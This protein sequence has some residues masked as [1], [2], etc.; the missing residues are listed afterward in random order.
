MGR[1]GADCIYLE[2]G[3]GKVTGFCG[4]GNEHAVLRNKVGIV[5]TSLETVSWPRR[6]FI[7]E[8]TFIMTHHKYRQL[9]EFWHKWKVNVT[10]GEGGSWDRMWKLRQK[11][12]FETEGGRWDR[13]WKLKQK[14][15]VETEVGSWDRKWKLRQKVEVETEG[16]SWNRRWKLREKVEVET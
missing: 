12:E 7:D 15:E 1:G 5:V 11:V 9:L 3:G 10:S 6:T 16:G 13:R 4:H 8:I 2:Q 14:M